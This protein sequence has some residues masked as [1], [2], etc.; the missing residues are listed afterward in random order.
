MDRD[1]LDRI[2]FRCPADLMVELRVMAAR[3]RRSVNNQ[4]IS[5]LEDAVRNAETK[6]AD[7]TA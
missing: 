1:N 5:M 3:S 2:T 7:A 6:K 4:L